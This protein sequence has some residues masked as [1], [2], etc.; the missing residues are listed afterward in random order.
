MVCLL[1]QGITANTHR[2]SRMGTAASKKE[3]KT[4]DSEIVAKQSTVNIGLV[5]TSENSAIMDNF[6]LWRTLQII[7]AIILVLLALR[8]LKKWWKRRGTNKSDDFEKQILSIVT[9][10]RQQEPSQ[11]MLQPISQPVMIPPALAP[12]PQPADPA[13][14]GYE[15]NYGK[16]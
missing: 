14:S 4:E 10:V 15:T 5:N 12:Y 7:S 16:H 2:S 11:L 3:T 1:L 13:R 8:W 9:R 6:P